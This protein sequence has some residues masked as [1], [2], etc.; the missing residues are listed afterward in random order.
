MRVTSLVR[1]D[2]ATKIQETDP[3]R[4][5]DNAGRAVVH[6]KPMSTALG[7]TTETAAAPSPARRR[8]Q[9]ERWFFSGMAVAAAA[10]TFAGFAPSYYLRPASG[11]AP[12]STL[13]HI[14]GV[15]FTSWIVLPVT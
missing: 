3:H 6:C 14:H 5:F 7:V 4:A 11:V 9:R 8:A 15:L 13:L 2:L 1:P 12:L 10:V